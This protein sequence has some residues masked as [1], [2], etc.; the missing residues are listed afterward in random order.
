MVDGGKHAARAVVFDV[1]FTAW[2]GSIP[3]RW[4]RPGEF[5]EIVQIGAVKVDAAFRPLDRFER[6]VRPRVNPQLSDYVMAVI[7]I[8]N[9]LLAASGVDF[10]D[11]WRDFSAFARGLPLIAYGRDDLVLAANLRLGGLGDALPPYLNAVDWL[12]A[13][14]VEFSH[15]HGCDIGPA[16]GVPFE[17]HPHD[18][19]DDTVSLAAGINALMARGAPSP[20]EMLVAPADEAARIAAA[21]ELQAHPEGGLFREIF[22]DA[23]GAGGRAHSTAIYYLLRAGEASR[24]HRIDAAEVWHHYRGAPL[25]LVIE[26]TGYPPVRHVLGPDVERGEEPQIV[27]PAHAWQSAR[28]LGDYALAGCT[29]APGFVFEMFEME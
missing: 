10:A 7:G 18:A 24:K 22:R 23:R 19:L 2:E 9:E 12:T 3:A 6:L 14:G 26:E 25:E 17:G 28:P 13:N 8:G 11:A 15:G 4:M 16:A 20:L 27:V 21:L 29:V 1:E 5:K